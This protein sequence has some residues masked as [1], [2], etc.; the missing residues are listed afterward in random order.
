MLNEIIKDIGEKELIKRIAKY[1]PSNQTSDD[2]AYLEAKKENL[3]IN[4]DVLVENTHFN[5]EIISPR[6]IGW[7]AV[8]TNYSDLISSGCIE[9]IGINIGF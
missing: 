4:T 6:D 7:K 5:H 3:L 9:F 2:C 8:I 1:M